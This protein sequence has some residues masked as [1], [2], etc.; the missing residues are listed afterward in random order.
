[1]YKCMKA[2]SIGDTNILYQNI[3]M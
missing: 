2:S 3:L 1:M